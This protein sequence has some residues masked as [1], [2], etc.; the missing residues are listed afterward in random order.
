MLVSKAEKISRELMDI[1]GLQD[2]TFEFDRATKRFGCTWQSLKRISLSKKLVQLNK[3]EHV[4]STILHEIAHALVPGGHSQD[5]KNKLISIGG[6]GKRFYSALE[7]KTPRPKGLVKGKCPNCKRVIFKRIK[8]NIAC[9]AC[10][11]EFNGG[12]YTE[13]YKV[14]WSTK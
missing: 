2:W 5:W 6:D 12:K 11:K 1:H 13:K 8:C 7:V 14:V 9:G 10:C 3:E 4:R